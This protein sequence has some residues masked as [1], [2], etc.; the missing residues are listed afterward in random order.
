MGLCRNVAGAA[1]ALSAAN[2]LAQSPYEIHG[3]HTELVFI[4]AVAKAEKLGGNCQIS[5]VRTQA[6]AKRALCE[7]A[8]CS[9]R[10]QDG[11]C[12]QQDTRTIGLTI[13]SQPILRISLEAPGDSA[14]LTLI[15]ILFEGNLDTV[16][17]SLQQEFGPP[18][19][20]GTPPNK[21]SWTP[22]H[23]LNWTQGHYR[24]GLLNSPKLIILGADRQQK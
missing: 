8:P 23:R 22:A 11:A 6:V 4:E 19:S 15:A 10:N 14:R 7:Y 9:A 13:A 5:T 2:T 17:A 3:L 1:L 12:E 21:Q 24:M 20:T 16:A 18:D